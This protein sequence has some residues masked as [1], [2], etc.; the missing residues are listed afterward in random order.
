MSVLRQKSPVSH[1]AQVEYRKFSKLLTGSTPNKESAT[2]IS[3]V[4]VT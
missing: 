4:L 1:Q 2:G 3:K